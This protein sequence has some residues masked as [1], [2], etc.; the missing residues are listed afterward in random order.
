MPDHSTEL[1]HIADVMED[2]LLC[3]GALGRPISVQDAIQTLTDAV[4]RIVTPL[5][6]VEGQETL[7]AIQGSL[8]RMEGHLANLVKALT[9]PAPGTPPAMTAERCGD[10]MEVLRRVRDNYDHDEVLCE[11]GTCRACLAARAIGAKP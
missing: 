7:E 4:D 11:Y 1:Q 5:H 2:A 9:P 6:P 8:E 10:M 3:T